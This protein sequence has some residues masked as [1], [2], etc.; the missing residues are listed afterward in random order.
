M[1]TNTHDAPIPPVTLAA[2]R[3][4]PLLAGYDDAALAQVAAGARL[5]RFRRGEVIFHRGDVGAALFIVEA[6]RVKIVVPT[7]SGEEALLTV[8]R[9]GDFFGELALLDGAPRSATA[10]ALEPVSL[11]SLHLADLLRPLL[12]ISGAAEMF[13]VLSRRL[14]RTDA[15]V[16]ELGYMDLDARLARTL[17]RLVDEHGID[18]PDGQTIDVPL[19]QT[20]LAAMVGA[21]RPRVNLLL[22]SYQDAGLLRLVGRTIVVCD[23]S[24]LRLRA[25]LEG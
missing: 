21:T 15:L 1:M 19:T 9:P 17:L 22:G 25:G 14:R 11:W 2:L 20:D 13:S 12:A 5:R 24:A 7:E 10:V 16:E 3:A 23:L 8:M 18:G 6:G 4:M